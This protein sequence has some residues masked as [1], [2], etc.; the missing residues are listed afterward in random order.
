MFGLASSHHSAP[1]CVIAK[2][3][4]LKSS[5]MLNPTMPYFVPSQSADLINDVSVVGASYAV[6]AVVGPLSVCLSVV[7]PIVVSH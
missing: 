3:S 7:C 6:V 2:N 5:G 4:T 1:L